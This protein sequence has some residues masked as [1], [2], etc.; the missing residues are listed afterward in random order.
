MPNLFVVLL[1]IE[2]ETELPGFLELFTE[3]HDLSL[4]LPL[5]L[6]VAHS[7][8]RVLLDLLLSLPRLLQ[9]LLESDYPRL[10]LYPLRIKQYG[11]INKRFPSSYLFKSVHFNPRTGGL[12]NTSLSCLDQSVRGPPDRIAGYLEALHGAAAL[13]GLHFAG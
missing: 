8:L 2:P 10:R 11:N 9:L 4:S 1:L 6:D 13:L 5:P 7:S 3:P 12:L